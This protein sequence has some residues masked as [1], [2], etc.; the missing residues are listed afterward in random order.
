MQNAGVMEHFNAQKAQIRDLR[1]WEDV[2]PYQSTDLGE[3]IDSDTR[4]VIR[5]QVFVK[6]CW[7]EVGGLTGKSMKCPKYQ[8]VGN[9][10]GTFRILSNFQKTHNI[11]L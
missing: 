2:H 5:V 3:Q 8:I 7:L 11:Y 1:I 9:R 4:F 10:S 6:L